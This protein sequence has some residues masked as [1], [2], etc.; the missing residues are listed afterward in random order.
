MFS[1]LVM[2]FQYPTVFVISIFIT[3]SGFVKPYSDKIS[4]YVEIFLA[5]NVLLLLLLRNTEQLNEELKHVPANKREQLNQ[6]RSCVDEVEYEGATK[7]VWLLFIFYYLPLLMS[8]VG[9]ILWTAYKLRYVE[10]HILTE[11]NLLS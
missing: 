3:I 9:V 4:N 8:L 11:Q 1:V 6:L 2:H 7:F 10:L 5:I